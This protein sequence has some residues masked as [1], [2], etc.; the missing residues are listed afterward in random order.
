MSSSHIVGGGEGRREN[1]QKVG[2]KREKLEERQ[3][4][5]RQ[6]R[7]RSDVSQR[8]QQRVEGA[9]T[10]GQRDVSSNLASTEWI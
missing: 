5:R 10:C 4:E 9:Q 6:A 1:R 7:E 3:N 2:R 8:W